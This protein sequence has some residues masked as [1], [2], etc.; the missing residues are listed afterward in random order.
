MGNGKG[1]EVTAHALQEPE[2]L[3]ALEAVELIGSAA[4]FRAPSSWTGRVPKTYESYR[5]FRTRLIESALLYAGMGA[6]R[7]LVALSLHMC[8]GLCL[9]VRESAS[10][11]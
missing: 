8:A 5:Y 3:P 11:H 4:V 6:S 1:E 2:D 7:L 9:H 10:V